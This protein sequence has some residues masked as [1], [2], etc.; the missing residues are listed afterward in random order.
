MFILSIFGLGP[1][2]ASRC[3]RLCFKMDKLEYVGGRFLFQALLIAG[4]R[5]SMGEGLS[6][7]S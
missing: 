4:T 2:I 6:F 1:P 3:A 7:V 5:D